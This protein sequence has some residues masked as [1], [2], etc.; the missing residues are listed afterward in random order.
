MRTIG[1][2]VIRLI[3]HGVAIGNGLNKNICKYMLATNDAAAAVEAAGYFNSMADTLVV[4]TQIDASLDLD[5]T[6]ARKDYI[7]SANAGGV[8]TI[9]AAT[10]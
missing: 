9:T 8:V 4:G 5:G 3:D 2:G 7:V 6:P 10:S 1:N